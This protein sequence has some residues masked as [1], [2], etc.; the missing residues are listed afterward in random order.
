M[1]MCNYK[2]I[3]I[4]FLSVKKAAIILTGA[5]FC[6]YFERF[7]IALYYSMYNVSSSIQQY[8]FK[9][10]QYFQAVYTLTALLYDVC[11]ISI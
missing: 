2:E 4:I 10:P 6:K 3:G 7:T 1:F 9:L 5:W 11:H 8:L